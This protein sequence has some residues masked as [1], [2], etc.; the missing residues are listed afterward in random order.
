VMPADVELAGGI[1]LVGDDVTGDGLPDLVGVFGP[2]GA[3]QNL[4]V[5]V[6]RERRGALAGGAAAPDA[7]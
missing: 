4:K 6:Q 3:P 7:P 1:T 5:L 2:E